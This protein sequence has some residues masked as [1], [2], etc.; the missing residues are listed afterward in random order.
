MALWDHPGSQSL[1]VGPEVFLDDTYRVPAGG[2]LDMYYGSWTAA[3]GVYDRYLDQPGFWCSQY[4]TNLVTGTSYS[5]FGAW[6]PQ[7]MRSFIQDETDVDGDGV[8]DH[9]DWHAEYG[10]RSQY[11]VWNYQKTRAAVVI[12]KLAHSTDDGTVKIQNR[13]AVATHADAYDTVP[14]GF[15][16]VS[17]YVEPDDQ[18]DLYGE[19][20][21]WRAGNLARA[22]LDADQDEGFVGYRCA[23]ARNGDDECYSSGHFLQLGEF[24]DGVEDDVA[25]EC[26]GTC[27]NPTFD[28]LSRD[29][30]TC[31]RYATAPLRR[32]LA[33]TTLGATLS[34]FTEMLSPGPTGPYVAPRGIPAPDTDRE[35]LLY[36]FNSCPYCHRVF[37]AQQRLGLDVPMADTHTDRSAAS[38]LR[39]LVGHTQVPCLVIDGVPLMESRDIIAWLEAY[40]T[41]DGGPSEQPSSPE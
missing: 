26:D 14:Y 18:R 15:R 5:S 24:T 34:W 31:S 32:H 1:I 16:L 8:E 33:D 2:S 38:T 11:N 28:Q 19:S 30:P 27:D 25:S 12:G 36:K 3:N 6:M 37:R 21:R 13:G 20:D 9:V 4:G 22:S 35:L 41:R 40:A 23:L 29:A 10:V 39:S 17:C 7:D